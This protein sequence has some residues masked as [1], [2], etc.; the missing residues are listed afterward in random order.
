MA[1]EQM[2]FGAMADGSNA[3]QRPFMTHR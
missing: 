1:E 2:V 3:A